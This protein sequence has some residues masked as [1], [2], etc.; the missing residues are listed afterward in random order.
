MYTCSWFNFIYN[1]ISIVISVLQYYHYRQ[2]G[3]HAGISLIIRQGRREMEDFL[4]NRIFILKT[5]QNTARGVRLNLTKA[6]PNWG[7]FEKIHPELKTFL[8]KI[9][10]Q[11]REN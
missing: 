3:D 4:L 9:E 5:H 10:S 1:C 2:I 6:T 11:I 8:E 7:K